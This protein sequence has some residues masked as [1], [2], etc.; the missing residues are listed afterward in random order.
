MVAGQ[1]AKEPA[2]HDTATMAA[3][4]RIPAAAHHHRPRPAVV[5]PG[6]DLESASE[7]EDDEDD[8][9]ADSNVVGTPAVERHEPRW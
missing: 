8:P 9:F 5:A 4:P 1:K 2:A 7:D 3:P 6:D